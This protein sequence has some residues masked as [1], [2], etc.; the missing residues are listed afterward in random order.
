MSG[1]IAIIEKCLSVNLPVA[2]PVCSDREAIEKIRTETIPITKAYVL[3]LN[4]QIITMRHTVRPPITDIALLSDILNVLQECAR[5]VSW[6]LKQTR[7]K[8][9]IEDSQE[10]AEKIKTERKLKAIESEA[11]S[12]REQKT[13][14]RSAQLAAERD[15]PALRDR[16][17]AIEGIMKT[18]GF[19]LEA[20]TAMLDKQVGPTQ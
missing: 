1:S 14:E 18:F 12:V 11:A 10:Y 16:R 20:A 7:D 17:K 15:N 8:I 4:N 13:A 3:A 5:D 9:S 2:H 6:V 19:T